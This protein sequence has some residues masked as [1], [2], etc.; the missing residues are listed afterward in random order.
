MTNG[1][2]KLTEIR[3]EIHAKKWPKAKIDYIAAHNGGIK[4]FAGVGLV[5]NLKGWGKAAKSIAYTLKTVGLADCVMGSSSMDFASQEGFENDGDAHALW[6]AAIEI[7]NWEV[8]G[9]A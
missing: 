6:S 7:Y 4:M 8:N 9:V 3:N 5:D 2:K 1:W